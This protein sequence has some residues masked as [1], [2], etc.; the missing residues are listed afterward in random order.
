MSEIAP[1]VLLDEAPP[2]GRTP[3]MATVVTVEPEGVCLRFDGETEPT[4]KLYRYLAGIKMEPNDR[5][6]LV[7]TSGTSV[8]VGVLAPPERPVAITYAETAGHAQTAETAYTATHATT[9]QESETSRQA[10]NAERAVSAAQADKATTANSA[11]TST[12]AGV[13]YD[14]SNNYY[15]V[16]F[17][18]S[19]GKIQAC[20]R[21]SNY[22]YNQ[23]IGWTDIT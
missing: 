9:A 21:M 4:K 10:T 20:V 17:R 12:Y 7:H 2:Q 1:D 16:R 23:L 19:G 18:A 22:P 14:D 8:I 11:T 3:D 6:L 5:V 13:V 15:A